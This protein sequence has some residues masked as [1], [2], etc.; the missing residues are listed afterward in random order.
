M[1]LIH[2]NCPVCSGGEHRLWRKVNGHSIVACE[3][4]GMRFVNPRPSE[5]AILRAYTSASRN[6]ELS[7]AHAYEGAGPVEDDHSWTGVYVLERFLRRKPGGSFL[8]IGAGQG[9][10][11]L[12][13]LKRGHDAYG[14]EFGDNRSFEKDDRIRGR[15]FSSEEA[16]AKSGKK[17]DLVFLSAVLEHVC[18]P[19]EFLKTWSRYLKPDGYFC[20]AAVP[21]SDSIFIRLGLDSWDG[22]IPLNHLNYFTPASLRELVNKIR[23]TMIELTTL[24]I[25]LNVSAANMVRQKLFETKF[26]GDNSN[27]WRFAQRADSQFA[28]PRQTRLRDA[29]TAT[30]NRLIQM[31]GAG[32]NLYTTFRMTT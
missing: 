26:W 32:A 30:G 2:V 7:F 24:G 25:P 22:N 31:S 23:G 12:E 8:D 9:W 21:N 18:Y 29:V 28:R 20:T 3:A 16:L 5:E 1:H 4:C 19:L 6:E 10:A 13:A 11:V 27:T 17:F 14:Y 15:I